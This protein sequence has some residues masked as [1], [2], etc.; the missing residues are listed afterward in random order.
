MAILYNI[1]HQFYKDFK[2]R[3]GTSKKLLGVFGLR[4]FRPKSSFSFILLRCW[5]EKWGVRAFHATTL[6][7]EF[8]LL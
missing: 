7:T 4:G 1:M 3:H 8:Q 6:I 2:V 5:V